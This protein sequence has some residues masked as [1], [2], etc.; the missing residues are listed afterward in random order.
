MIVRNSI[1]SFTLVVSLAVAGC[2]D[3]NTLS[4]N[5]VPPVTTQTASTPPTSSSPIPGLPTSMPAGSTYTDLNDR[6]CKDVARGP[7]DEG[8]I[9]KGECPG[10]AGYKVINLS[11]DHTQALKI[12]DPAGKRHDVDFRGPLGTAAD[13]FLGDK[14]EWRT[15]GS[16]KDAKPHAFIIR[17][18][19][20]K[21]PGNYD[22][23]D[24]NLAVVKI[25]ADNICV[26]D[27]VPPSVKDQNVKA[28]ELSDTAATKP[29]IKSK[30]DD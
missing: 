28:R 2:S 23:Q 14:I 26:T 20:Q 21:E 12:T 7:D 3:S 5:A 25:G 11:T 15:K 4:N 16:E 17:V 8:I 30:F 10:F 13:V 9:Y 24:S 1:V 29:C 6:V 22:K 19:V 27:L 18:N